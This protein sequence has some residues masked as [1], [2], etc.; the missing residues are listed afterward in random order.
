MGNRLT[1]IPWHR[2]GERDAQ[3]WGRAALELW[4]G[5]LSH[6]DEEKCLQQEVEQHVSDDFADAGEGVRLPAR[7]FERQVCDVLPAQT[8]ASG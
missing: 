4:G 3:I 5:C 6:L 7:H 1:I 8:R 2:K